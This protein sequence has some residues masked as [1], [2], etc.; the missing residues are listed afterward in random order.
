MKNEL[1]TYQLIQDYLRGNLSDEEVN[2]F[3]ERLS[4]DSEFKEMYEEEKNFHEMTRAAIKEDIAAEVNVAFQKSK[5][6]V[7]R[8]NWFFGLLAMTGLGIA[9]YFLISN[10]EPV[11]TVVNPKT[12]DSILI[13]EETETSVSSTP[14]KELKTI[15]PEKKQVIRQ[16]SEVVRE[17]QEE[18][19]TD[20]VFIL[21]QERIVI[22]T[23]E[24]NNRNK[25]HS[26]VEVVQQQEEKVIDPCQSVNVE[27]EIEKTDA[28]LFGERGQLEIVFTSDD[29]TLR[30]W[31]NGNLMEE[32]FAEK[33]STG[34]YQ[35]L[36]K[37][38]DNCTVYNEKVL[39]KTKRCEDLPKAFNVDQEVWIYP[40]NDVLVELTIL[41]KYGK[42]LVTINAENPE[43]D[44]HGSNGEQLSTDDYI[45]IVSKEGKVIDKG[46]VTLV[47]Q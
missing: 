37:N 10:E 9:G 26:V 19:N 34:T 27:V 15:S 22:D 14:K 5:V 21:P 7:Q 47:R 3:E 11:N 39:I 17:D 30:Y 36:V 31:L 43:W 42:K 46:N 38:L 2:S 16:V 44:G 24:S 28:C 6:N 4:K 40:T 13:S 35:V 20:T 18:Q 23:A 1:E 33:L 29:E 41:S 12:V 32:P 45:F 25:S 8:R